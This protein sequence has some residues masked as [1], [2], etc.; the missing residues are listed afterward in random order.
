MILHQQFLAKVGFAS[1]VLR[2]THQL[3]TLKPA[4][5]TLYNLNLKT[6]LLM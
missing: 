6:L 4:I 2:V 5:S 3:C 1:V